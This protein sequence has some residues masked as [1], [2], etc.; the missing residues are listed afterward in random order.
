[1]PLQKTVENG[2]VIALL[3]GNR[4]RVK[5]PRRSTC[6]GCSHRSFCDPFGTEHMVV[7]AHNPARARTGQKVEVSFGREKQSTA[8]FILY[9]IPLAAL[10][11]GA[12]VGNALDP[13]NNQNASSAAL[14]ILCV[15][16]S[17]VGIRIYSRKRSE[18]H[19]DKQPVITSILAS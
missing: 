7:E 19:P 16:L 1:M 4:A 17:F 9:I 18:T 8:I 11:L 12:A 10:I 15:A 6:Q 2:E 5:I 3:P 13:F 14:S